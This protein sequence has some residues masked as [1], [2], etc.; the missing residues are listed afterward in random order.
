MKQPN[1]DE[2]APPEERLA[3]ASAADSANG[4]ADDSK[5]SARRGDPRL[6]IALILLS[7][8]L[9]FSLFAI[10]FL[11][12]TNGQKA[13]LAGATFLGVQAAWWDGAALAGPRVVRQVTGWMR[14]LT[15]GR[16]QETDES[17]S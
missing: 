8:V 5:K 3:E 6:G 4:M 15:G 17:S 7:G 14:M 1:S 12:L 11:P 16:K 10:P 13:M 2:A 9:W